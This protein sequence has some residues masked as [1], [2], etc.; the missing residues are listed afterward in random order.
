MN[1]DILSLYEELEDNFKN[2][3]NSILLENDV[4]RIFLKPHGLDGKEFYK[5]FVICAGHRNIKL[6]LR[7]HG[8]IEIA[9]H[10]KR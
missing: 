6:L 5:I 7:P 9:E 10:K 2:K 1:K 8:G 4:I 3:V